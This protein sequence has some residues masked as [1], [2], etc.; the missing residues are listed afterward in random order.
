MIH[1]PGI[2]LSGMGEVLVATFAVVLAITLV[3]FIVFGLLK[4]L[5]FTVGRL[6][7]FVGRM[8]N[9]AA[10]LVGATLTAI[11]MMF[12][13]LGNVVIGRW[14][15]ARHFGSAFSTECAAFGAALFRLSFSHWLWFFGLENVT[16]GLEK[17]LPQ[18]IAAAPGPTMDAIPRR[19]APMGIAEQSRV[20]Q[21]RM[22]HSP[23]PPPRAMSEQE[24]SDALPPANAQPVS[25]YAG[26]R[27][28]ATGRFDGYQ[29]V[30]TLAG[31]GSGGKLYVARPDEL[32]RASFERQGFL[33]V[34]DVVIKAFSV[35]EGSSLPQIVRESR[36]LE[37]AKKLG[38]VLEH[39]LTPERFFYVMQYVPGD[40][41]SIMTQR[42]HAVSESAGLAGEQLRRAVS[43]VADL[44]ATLDQYHRAGLWHKDIKPDNIIVNSTDGRAHLVDFGL[45]T[46][47][48]SSMTLTTHGTEYFRDPEM[49]R[50]ALKGVKVADV[51]GAKFDVYGAGAVLFSILE[52]SF[53]AHGALSQVSKRCPEP[54]RWII[55]RAMTDYDKRYSSAS[56]MLLDLRA[57]LT[58][59]EPMSMRVADLPSMKEGGEAAAAI[60]LPEFTPPQMVA[61]TF[62]PS[63]PVG[64]AG[65]GV[66]NR[67]ALG[68]AQEQLTRARERMAQRRDRAIA[69]IAAR[70]G[71]QPGA[72]VAPIN[73]GMVA[74]IVIGGIFVMMF[75]GMVFTR[76]S[77][78]M[79]SSFTSSGTSS[80]ARDTGRPEPRP[81][82]PVSPS[83]IMVNDTI[84]VDPSK[85]A[86][87]PKSSRKNS[88]TPE[89]AAPKPEQ[90]I[91]K[92][93]DASILVIFD[94]AASTAKNEPVVRHQLKQLQ[95]RGVQLLASHAGIIEGD[96]LGIDD[97]KA[98][99]LEAAAR[100]AVGMSAPG[101]ADA[102]KALRGWLKGVSSGSETKIRAVVWFARRADGKGEI[103]AW[104]V[105]AEDKDAV[106]VRVLRAALS[107]PITKESATPAA[108]AT[109]ATPADPDAPAEQ[110]MPAEPTESGGGAGGG[111]GG[112]KGR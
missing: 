104:M 42:L 82:A 3:V 17:R 78:R 68:T 108:P 43:Y 38:L 97:E 39:Q 61:G 26:A 67:K 41:L 15:A 76:Q 59:A 72:R 30:G 99:E 14:S 103:M 65:A 91:E 77:P 47:L 54:L 5:S 49:V 85:P 86:A 16:E 24:T 56:A 8:L 106:C 2:Q 9:D 70:R 46:P 80:N 75:L 18:A 111:A 58:S 57:V 90:A 102:V 32:K 101:S 36:A 96:E 25:V 60:P 79:S 21:L 83:L 98:K 73:K 51:D 6:A 112:G 28:T 69:R 33:G 92:I 13:S 66:K 74:G 95:L 20:D 55:R 62:T 29:I 63:T 11:A 84:A 71:T 48:R 87:T 12:M 22:A 93:E 27:S 7:R 44:V 23:V 52:N 31:G 40:S 94:P 35:R 4:G 37:A 64:P 53:P 105:P 110:P 88:K 81:A 19:A 45:L 34:G 100:A 109:P 89:P 1:I 10:R 50:M 107:T